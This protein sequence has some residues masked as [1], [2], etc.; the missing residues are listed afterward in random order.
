[1]AQFTTTV[2]QNEFLPDGGTDVSA[3]VTIACDG[4]GKAGQTGAGEAGEIIMVDTSGSMSQVNMELAKQAAMAAVDQLTDGTWFALVAG[5][6]RAY[7]AY[8]MVQSG[9]GMV[10]ANDATRAAAKAA[11]A[12]F[13]ADGGTAIGEW[14]NL[15]RALFNSV[16][17]L[18]H[19]H[20]ILLTDGE[21]NNET[22]AQLDKAI[23]QCIGQ[24]QCDC[25]GIGSEWKV[26]ELRK[27][28]TALIGTVD[29]VP[30]PQQLSSVFSDLMRISM[31]RGVAEAQLRLWVP[32]G[33]QILFVRQ[34]SPQLEDFTA[35]GSAI[36]PLTMSYPTGSWGNEQRDYHIAVRLPAKAIGQ[37]QLAARVQITLGQ[38]VVTQGLVKAMWSG[39]DELTTNIDSRVAHYTGQTELATAIQ[40]GLAAKKAGDEATATTRLGRAVQIAAASGNVE[41]TTRLRKVV[42]VTDEGT[43]TVR[44]KRSVDKADEIALDTASIKTT[45]IRES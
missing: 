9:A 41:A 33:A 36:N 12:W 15:T 26:Y 7:L 21:N 35:R 40:E 14:L 17:G 42:D 16:P 43:G 4:A 18:T 5:N 22:P 30:D 32:Q 31:G 23:Y 24:F 44:L 25:R 37:E 6:H 3:I 1:M 29:L 45:R 13:R 19:K 34:V 20:A 38:E 27:I 10:K 39:D 28:A 11:I 2:Y 8:P